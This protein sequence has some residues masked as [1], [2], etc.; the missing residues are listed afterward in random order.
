MHHV[1]DPRTGQP[2]EEVWRTVSVAAASCVDANTA[3]TAA[4]VQGVRAPEWLSRREL[5]ARLVRG[6]G[7]VLCVGG[8]PAAEEACRP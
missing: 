8:W 3:S 2:A 6:D 1:V 7:S 5:P 4:V